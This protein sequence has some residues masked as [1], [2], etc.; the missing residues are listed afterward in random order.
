MG[1]WPDANTNPFALIACEY[2]PIASGASLV[3]IISF[4]VA[5]ASFSVL[6][7]KGGIL[8]ERFR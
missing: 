7:M 6:Q 3:W 4:T 8:A 1:I 2:G 5:N